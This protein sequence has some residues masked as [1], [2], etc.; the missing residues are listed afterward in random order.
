[1]KFT[2]WVDAVKSLQPV[3]AFNSTSN[4]YYKT[5]LPMTM[6]ALQCVLAVRD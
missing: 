3:Y 6:F 2:L 5:Q 1:M 4:L